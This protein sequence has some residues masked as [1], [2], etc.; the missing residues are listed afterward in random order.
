MVKKWAWSVCPTPCM[1]VRSSVYTPNQGDFLSMHLRLCPLVISLCL[2]TSEHF[3]FPRFVIIMDSYHDSTRAGQLSSSSPAQRTG[4]EEA[5]RENSDG[6]IISSKG[7]K[8]NNS[9]FVAI[10]CSSAFW[11]LDIHTCN[12]HMFAVDLCMCTHVS[13]AFRTYVSR[14]FRTRNYSQS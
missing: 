3:Y 8:G 1:I 13:R 14:A 5:G 12:I 10:Y 2:L 6:R 7:R 9:C 4:H 11:N